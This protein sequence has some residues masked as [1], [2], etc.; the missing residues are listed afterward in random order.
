[1]ELLRRLARSRFEAL[2]RQFQAEAYSWVMGMVHD[3]EIAEEQLC[4]LGPAHRHSPAKQN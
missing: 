3:P 2:V 4:R 1:M